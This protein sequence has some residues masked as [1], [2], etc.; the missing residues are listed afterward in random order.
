[1]DNV[2]G[3]IVGLW[4]LPMMLN[5]VLPLI[6]LSVWLV[7]QAPAKLGLG[8]TKQSTHSEDVQEKRIGKRVNMAD[9]RVDVSDGFNQLTGL[10]CNISKMGICIKGLPEKVFKQAEQLAVIVENKGEQFSL[11]V[12]PRWEIIKE[13][14]KRIGA[15]IESAPV[16]WLEFVEVRTNR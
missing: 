11:E 10:A 5:I 4:F 6:M 9:I 2:S 12:T 16:G 7:V 13:S 15:K 8:V 3:F 14:S 1:M